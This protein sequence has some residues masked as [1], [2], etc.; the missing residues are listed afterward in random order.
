MKEYHFSKRLDERFGYLGINGTQLKRL[1]KEIR[2][3]K[4]ELVGNAL[5]GSLMYL[6]K[7]KRGIMRWIYDPRSDRLITAISGGTDN[8]KRM[9]KNR[10]YKSIKTRRKAIKENRRKVN[11]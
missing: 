9:E 6:V 5:G 2:A 3:G 4:H 7:Y 1:K 8:V 10:I 11:I